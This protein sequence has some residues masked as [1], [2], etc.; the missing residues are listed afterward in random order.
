MRAPQANAF[1]ERFVGT[2]RREC[3]DH[4]LI[5]GECHL[6]GVLASWQAHYNNH[7]PHQ[8]LDHQAPND[9]PC[10]VV[11]LAPAIQRRQVLGGLINEYIR[12]A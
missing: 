1:A 2:V 6:H 8:G 10:R 9:R 11:D 4:L 5:G 7:R 3:L 12:A